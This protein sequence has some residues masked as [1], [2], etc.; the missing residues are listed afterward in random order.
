MS[1]F[2]AVVAL[3]SG[4]IGMIYVLAGP[5]FVGPIWWV[6]TLL[7]LVALPVLNYLRRIAAAIEKT[8]E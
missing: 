5:A 3:I 1:T 7:S 8:H 2:L 6:I 4:L